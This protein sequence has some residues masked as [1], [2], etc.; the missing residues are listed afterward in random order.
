MGLLWLCE[1]LNA[2]QLCDPIPLNP[3][4]EHQSS[5]CWFK[6][7]R[8]LLLGPQALHI[9][10]RNFRLSNYNYIAVPG[11]DGVHP[12]IGAR[13]PRLRSNDA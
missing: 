10:K 2:S 7:F 8:W 3:G 6:W 11:P 12:N 9:A 4:Y 5:L 13:M 1:L